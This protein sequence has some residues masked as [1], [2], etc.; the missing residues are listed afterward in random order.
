M[1]RKDSGEDVSRERG[2]GKGRAM[3][4]GRA[5]AVCKERGREKNKSTAVAMPSA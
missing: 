3:W 1:E 2:K 5:E 4:G